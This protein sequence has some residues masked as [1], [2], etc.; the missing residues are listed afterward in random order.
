MKRHATLIVG[1]GV[2]ALLGAG[3]LWLKKR[4]AP[5]VP[6]TATDDNA[7]IAAYFKAHPFTFTPGVLEDAVRAKQNAME[8]A[9]VSS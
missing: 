5:G 7:A 8:N 4:H 3:Y 1:A 6:A 9:R 2:V